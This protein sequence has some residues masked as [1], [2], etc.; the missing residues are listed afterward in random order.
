MPNPIFGR[1]ASEYNLGVLELSGQTQTVD[2][3]RLFLEF[4]IY[5][6]ILENNMTCDITVLD[7]VG[8]FNNI[9]IVGGE[10]QLH[11]IVNSPL[12]D[13]VS[14]STDDIDMIFTIYNVSNRHNYKDRTQVYVL[15]G[16]TPEAFTSA[17]TKINRSYVSSKNRLCSDIAVDIFD[18][19]LN[20]TADFDIEPTSNSINMIFPAHWSPFDGINYL[21]SKSQSKGEHGGSSYFFFENSNGYH[22]KSLDSLSTSEPDHL[23]VYEPLNV[24]ATVL[25]HEGSVSSYTFDNMFDALNN[26][27]R[28]MMH[29]K[30]VVHDLTMK[31]IKNFSNTYNDFFNGIAGH[32]HDQPMFNK[33]FDSVNSEPHKLHMGMA[34]SRVYDSST[35]PVANNISEV[36][37]SRTARLQE[38]NNIHMI[39]SIPGNSTIL[40]GDTV[41]F[42][43]PNNESQENSG[44]INDIDSVISGK[45][46]V[47]TVR[48]KVDLDNY[49][50][51]LTLVKD[52]YHESPFE[53]L[54]P[55]DANTN[56]A[57]QGF[58]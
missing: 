21:A 7:G 46:L 50:T 13:G 1:S 35:T 44:D 45:F 54:N 51:I 48:H 57:R 25:P 27:T 43:L 15:H 11:I 36:L 20:T 2:I 19:D 28:G 4:N 56:N 47:L 40:A 34:S 26:T 58:F 32:V 17:E 22:F 12:I 30:I 5:E 10:T 8:L 3:S 39:A 33:Q 29:S 9:P 52:S 37:L 42:D 38:S 49:V 23:L 14:S 41:S 24:S 55:I 53:E 31:T 16:I 18:K 6:S